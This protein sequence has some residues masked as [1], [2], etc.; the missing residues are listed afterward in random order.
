MKHKNKILIFIVIVTLKVFTLQVFAENNCLKEEVCCEKAVDTF[1][2]SY[3]KDKNIT[4]LKNFS[5]Y[6]DFLWMNFFED[7][8]EYASVPNSAVALGNSQDFR[9]GFRVGFSGTIATSDLIFDANWTYIRFKRKE[10]IARRGITLYH[11]FLPP[12]ITTAFTQASSVLSGDFNNLDLDLM[13]PYHVFRNFT[14]SPAFGL[15]IAYIDQDYLIRYFISSVK[16]TVYCKNDFWGAGLNIK[17]TSE[18]LLS[19]NI[20]IYGLVKFA[21]LFGKF[22][23]TQKANAFVTNLDYQIEDSFYTVVPSSEI[24]AG[25]SYNRNFNKNRNKITIKAGYEFHLWWDQN[26]LRRPMDSDPNAM[27]KV[28]KGNLTFNGFA[29]S[30]M[31]DF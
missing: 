23:I 17:N 19:K 27:K 10:E 5:V 15:S 7:G 31:V 2:F 12:F 24:S 26:Q 16:N 28:A 14:L 29:F 8:L 20:S 1:A 4:C 21:I 9:P 11:F 13:K 25:L 18:L 6:A 30:L 3:P 22:D